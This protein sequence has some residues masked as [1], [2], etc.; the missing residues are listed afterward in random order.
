MTGAVVGLSVV[1]MLVTRTHVVGLIVTGV[2]V[3][4]LL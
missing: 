4:G 3:L 2:S 1:E